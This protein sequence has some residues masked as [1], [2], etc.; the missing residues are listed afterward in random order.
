MKR[1]IV[2][3]LLAACISP[4][5]MAGELSPREALAYSLPIALQVLKNMEKKQGKTFSDDEIRAV[6]RSL[7]FQERL[8]E[9]VFQKRLQQG[10]LKLPRA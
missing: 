7:E 10:S 2:A 5:A 1:L 9:A 6:A 3:F 4:V 8:Q